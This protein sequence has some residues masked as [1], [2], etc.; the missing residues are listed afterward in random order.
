MAR[1]QA[2]ESLDNVVID[3]P[4]VTADEEE[5]WALLV[6]DVHRRPRKAKPHGVAWSN[7]RVY[8]DQWLVAA[9]V[10]IYT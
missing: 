2:G 6:R 10:L 9:V 7:M 5:Q 4:V 8:Y 3:V 1:Q